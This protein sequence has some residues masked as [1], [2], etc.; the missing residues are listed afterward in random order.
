MATPC[1]RLMVKPQLDGAYVASRT[2]PQGGR[3]PA[4]QPP[5]DKAAPGAW[6]ILIVTDAWRPQVNG[7]V[8]TLT[9]TT[10]E[11]RR[12]GHQV[13]MISPLDFRTLPLPS[14]PEIRLAILPGR[15]VA[16]R[17]EAFKPDVI[18]IA[19]EGPLGWAARR[20]CLRN[21]F[22]FTTAYHTQFPQY[23]QLRTRLPLKYGYALMRRFHGPSQRVMVPT[24]AMQRELQAQG[25]THTG[26][27]SRGV[28]LDVFR[29]VA[30]DRLTT[31]PPIFLYVGRVAVE[32]NIQAFLELDLPGSKWVCGTGPMEAELRQRY[33]E[34]HWE[35]VQTQ[36]ELARFYAAADVMVFPSRTDTFGLV[37]LEAMACGCPVAAFPVTGPLDVIGD[38]PG[39]VM[40]EDLRTACLQALKISRADARAHAERYSWAAATAQFACLLAPV[41]DAAGGVPVGQ[42]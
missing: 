23:I 18:H 11:L 12:L 41:G 32:K 7:V 26:L 3:R 9:Q 42:A 38:G 35:G 15:A 34:V 25:F 24:G 39:G 40:H 8:R 22:P 16:R 17:I 21:N 33:P 31:E 14:Y 28:D 30:R 37:L 13:E 27:W 5:Q 36:V 20:W 1:S 4:A 10:E 29:P 19:T 2:V 6:R